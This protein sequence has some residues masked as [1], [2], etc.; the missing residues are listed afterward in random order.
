[1]KDKA[2]KGRTRNGGKV[3]RKGADSPL[4]KLNVEQARTIR[5]SSMTGAAL[6]K[7][8]G[9]SRALVSMIKNGKHYKEV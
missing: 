9:V 2:A 5:K 1:M 8:Y 4:A 7:K 6:A 3:Q